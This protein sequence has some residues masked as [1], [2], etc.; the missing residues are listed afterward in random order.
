[1]PTYRIIYRPKIDEEEERILKNIFGKDN[2]VFAKYKTKGI[3]GGAFDVQIIIDTLNDPAVTA[4][5]HGTELVSLL[6]LLVKKLFH[7]NT[8]K[9]M[10]NNTRPRYTSL[11][12]KRENYSIVISNINK[13]NK[14]LISK[15]S[16]DFS[17]IKKQI[18][19]GDVEYTEEKLKG[20]LKDNK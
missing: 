15:H 11:S 4:L 3:L 13:D 9:I 12:I 17:E 18:E 2:L 6:S 7:R 14:I 10:D 16:S 5:I 1:M 19:M 20:Y 8:K